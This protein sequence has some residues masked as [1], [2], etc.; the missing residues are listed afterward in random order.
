MVISLPS[1]LFASQHRA[2]DTEIHAILDGTGTASALAPSLAALRLHLYAEEQILFPAL[3]KTSAVMAIIAMKREH[4]QMW[5]PMET[6]S[7]ACM[8]ASPVAALHD[9]CSELFQLLQIHNPKEEKII[10]TAADRLVAARH[11]TALVQA[12]QA[13]KLPDGWICEKAPR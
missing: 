1:Q 3:A 5:P 6:L 9:T 12:L 2:I 13:A 8:S 4:G 7:A 11:D 10:Y